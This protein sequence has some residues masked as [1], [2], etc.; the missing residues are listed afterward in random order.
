MLQKSSSFGQI[1]ET[2]D[3]YSETTLLW[4]K[5]HQKQESGH[6]YQLFPDNPHK[7]EIWSN[8]PSTLKYSTLNRD[9]W[10]MLQ[11]DGS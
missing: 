10:I 9:Q 1:T 4:Q 6:I 7:T 11:C 5:N 2:N 3:A 8:L